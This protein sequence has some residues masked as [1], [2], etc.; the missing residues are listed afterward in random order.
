MRILVSVLLLT[1][2]CDVAGVPD[3]LPHAAANFTCGPADGPATAIMLARDPITSAGPG[4]PYVQVTIDAWPPADLAGRSWIVGSDLVGAWYVPESRA[5]EI[6]TI[7][8]VQVVRVDSDS[9]IHGEVSLAF[10]SRRVVGTFT[11]AWI[12]RSGTLCG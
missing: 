8:R 10:P 4:L 2:A 9:T 5:A 6:A 11:A 12:E 1:L 7:G 3:D